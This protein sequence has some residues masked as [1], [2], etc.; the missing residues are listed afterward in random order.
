MPWDERSVDS[1]ALR[2]NPLGDPHERPLF[3]WTPLDTSRRY[4]TVY[5]LHSH[6]RAARWWF[7]VEPF[8]RSYPDTVEA[9]EPEAIVVLV[10]G[11]TSVGG[12][13]WIDSTGIGRYG[14]YLR[15]E[16]VPFVDAHFPTL[17]GARHRGLQGSSSGGYGA[18]VG[19]LERPDVF[20]AV[21]MHAPDALF[22]VSAAQ[23]FPAAA[24]MLREGFDGSLERFWSSFSTLESH[25]DA[26][27]V[28]LYAGS[29]AYSD[30]ALPFDPETAT[31]IPEI[32]ERWL[33]HDPVRLV[34]AHAEAARGLRGI[35]LDAGNA[36]A[37][38]L[39]LAALALRREL[40][41]AGVP[42]DRF[43]F[44]LFEGGHSGLDRR[45][46]LSLAWLV[47]RLAA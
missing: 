36:D 24:R 37:Y 35:W 25:T 40:A 11:W 12:S 8:E 5:V 28:E 46:P 45:Y 34:A 31:P 13:Q 47:E 16:V 29:L 39:D 38:F 3:V 27:L 7:N 4:P 33:E 42:E 15:D 6:M 30:G 2:G 43:H 20:G 9:L 23:G 19:A 14:T 21:A 26:L 22:E 17:P 32:W 10:D 18:L 44:E 41:G 1:E